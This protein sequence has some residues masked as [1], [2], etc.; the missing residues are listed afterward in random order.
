MKNYA[1]L[2]LMLTATVYSAQNNPEINQLKQ[3]VQNQKIE[4]KE[5]SQQNN[6]YRETLNLLKPIKSLDIDGL[7]I[8]IITVTASKKDMSLKIEFMYKNTNSDNRTFFQCEQAF[9][10]D[11]QGNQYQTYDIAAG[12][13]K[14]I[15]VENVRPNIPHK[16]SM[17]FKITNDSVPMIKELSLKFYS[18]NSAKNGNV[19]TAIFENLD[20]NWN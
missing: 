20:I 19:Q 17:L 1:L 6:Y 5:L 14:N 2:L 3:V 11:P 16:G 15:R 13:N 18:N 7:Q 10:I 8:D 9:L 12:A 4:I